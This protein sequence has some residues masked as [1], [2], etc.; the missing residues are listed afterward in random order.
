M[1]FETELKRLGLKDKEAAVY[2]ACLEL[3]PSSVQKIAR[4]SG[5]VRATTYVILEDLMDRG[6][7]TKYKEGK[8][9]LFSA[10]PPQM[11]M[12]LL[13]KQRE[14]IDEKQHD[15]ELLL[16]ELQILMKSAKG[17]P[18]VRYFDGVEGMQA[19]RREMLMYSKSGD[20]WYNF[21]PVDH[22]DAVFGR[23]DLLYY[24][25]RKAKQIKARTI[26]TTKSAKLRDQ[27]L[28]G[29]EDRYT[30]RRYVPP[31]YF[32]SAGGMTIF[33]DRVAMGSFIGKLGG[34]IIESPTMADMMRRMFDLAWMGAEKMSPIVPPVRTSRKL[35][36]A[37]I[38]V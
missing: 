10:E 33:R 2:I 30:E 28:S 5:V 20:V 25:Q 8:K 14:D 4:K 17:R 19:M 3:G 18:T 13:E 7:A 35:D 27:I 22:L 38:S 32:P 9:T 15:L 31:D 1:V 12:R 6:L 24:Q 37:V 16:P 26:F 29:A 11:L 34:V 21:T 36:R 23:R